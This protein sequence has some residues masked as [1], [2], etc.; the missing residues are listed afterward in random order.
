MARIS[1][2][3]T[4]GVLRRF[5]AVLPSVVATMACGTEESADDPASCDSTGAVVFAFAVSPPYPGC[6]EGALTFEADGDVRCSVF[7]GTDADR[8]ECEGAR[9]PIAGQSCDSLNDSLQAAG[10]PRR[11]CFCGLP[12]A[13]GEVMKSCQRE[14]DVGSESAWCLLDRVCTK[15][16]TFFE[17]CTP[18][19][20]SLLRVI[21]ESPPDALYLFGCVPLELSYSS[22]ACP[23]GI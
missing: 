12:Q 20:R 17:G 16:G 11:P 23:P 3:A 13:S 19:A 8:C 10:L 2:H 7:E 5:V 21:G 18:E 15:N 9:T 14:A 4:G 6:L 1:I 22:A